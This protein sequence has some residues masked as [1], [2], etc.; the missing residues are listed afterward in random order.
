MFGAF[1]SSLYC[2]WL[3]KPV[4]PSAPDRLISTRSAWGKVSAFEE[5]AALNGKI[6]KI[7]DCHRDNDKDVYFHIAQ[8]GVWAWITV[9]WLKNTNTNF[10]LTTTS[11][12]CFPPLLTSF[13]SPSVSVKLSSNASTCYRLQCSSS[14]GSS[15]SL[16][17]CVC[18]A[19]GVGGGDFW[20]AGQSDEGGRLSA[21]I[22]RSCCWEKNSLNPLELF[23]LFYGLTWTSS[24]RKT[25]TFKTCTVFL[26]FCKFWT[27]AYLRMKKIFWLTG[28]TSSVC[29]ELWSELQ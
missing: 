27:E 10:W 13:W 7:A 3:N 5:R 8:P 17:V 11:N 26:F 15:L 9:C 14:R 16:H 29:R 4:N 2:D 21:Q 25:N 28:A 1:E 22:W 23:F 12:A 20:F 6:T 18:S 24:F 19:V